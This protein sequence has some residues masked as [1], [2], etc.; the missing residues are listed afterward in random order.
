[1]VL[2][3]N[4]I[5][6]IDLGAAAEIT[7]GQNYLVSRSKHSIFYRPPE[8]FDPTNH[9]G[10]SSDIYQ[11]GLV[12]YEL[13]NGPIAESPQHYLIERIVR[14]EEARLRKNYSEMH[15]AER[16]LIQE[17]SIKY[18]ANKGRLLEVGKKPRRLYFKELSNIVKSLTNPNPSRRVQSCSKARI[19]LSSYAGPNWCELQDGT[20][21]INNYKG[22]DYMAQEQVHTKGPAV[23]ICKSSVTGENNYR[24]CNKIKS[25]QEFESIIGS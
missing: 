24:A 6:I 7:E 8:A 12:L 11:V 5:K 22:R 15:D 25:W 18:L 19:L 1:M 20:I 21:L 2:A 17:E 23:F 14:N 9:Y 13:I 10:T 16:S 4:K 3:G